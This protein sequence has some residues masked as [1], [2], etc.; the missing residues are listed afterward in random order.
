MSTPQPHPCAAALAALMQ[1]HGLSYNGL[2]DRAADAGHPIAKGTISNLINGKEPDLETA[3]KLARIFARPV[4]HFLPELAADV[5]A[6]SAPADPKHGRV[7][8][9]AL[10]L[11]PI[12]ERKS[13]DTSL[14]DELA[15][16]I[17]ERGI[18]QNLNVHPDP[19]AEG[20]WLVAAG[21]RR[22]RACKM[23]EG[24]NR[25]PPEITQYGLPV[26]FC[27]DEKEAL[28]VTVVE[29]LHREDPHPL[30]RASAYAR[31]RD[32]LEWTSDQIAA[33][34]HKSRDHVTQY[35][36]VHDRLSPEDKDRLLA[37]EITFTDARELVAVPG[38]RGQ[39]RKDGQEEGGKPDLRAH[40]D[41]ARR[42]I[43]RILDG[44]L[45][46]DIEDLAL[47]MECPADPDAIRQAYEAFDFLTPDLWSH[48]QWF[49]ENS[50]LPDED[51]D[52]R[53][54]DILDLAREASSGGIPLR[55]GAPTDPAQPPLFLSEGPFDRASVAAA[56]S[57]VAREPSAGG[58]SISARLAQAMQVGFRHLS[59]RHITAGDRLDEDLGFDG[60]DLTTLRDLIAREFGVAVTQDDL[61]R[62]GTVGELARHVIRL[63]S[64]VG[65]GNA[66]PPQAKAAWRAVIAHGWVVDGFELLGARFARL[67]LVH[68]V[69]GERMTFIP[70]QRDIEDGGNE[71]RPSAAE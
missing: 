40:N 4:T 5:G 60:T 15:A 61:A 17:A 3:R 27:R 33:S 42:I 63:L 57:T 48:L 30:D 10:R 28:V 14:L 7:K 55:D 32:E 16:D 19:Q 8:L 36:R 56:M 13:F 59:E 54:R 67:D 58:V 34:V 29:N 68:T 65:S 45:D 44:G 38:A 12:N 71:R 2:R 22:W 52:R 41:E 70:T 18:L 21:G 20:V 37:G 23:L 39:Q 9:S 26:R 62:L 1:E 69:T 31:L 35:L 50:D 53:L 49:D 47:K 6:T 66:A 11:S 43:R 25:L 51:A 64:M 24:Q 46:G